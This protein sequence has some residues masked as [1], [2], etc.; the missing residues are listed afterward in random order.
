MT[1]ETKT[2]PVEGILAP[3]G[4]LVSEVGASAGKAVDES[5]RGI[6]RGTKQGITEAAEVVTGPSDPDEW[7]AWNAE[8]DR[9]RDERERRHDKRL[10]RKE[11]RQLS[12]NLAPIKQAMGMFT[13]MQEVFGNLMG[14]QTQP[15]IN[16]DRLASAMKNAKV[17]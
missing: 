12:K 15:A 16:Y 2:G 8:N 3:V 6:F 5:V 4:N 7:D 1:S 10:Q 13:A 14:G 11:A 17:D 9:R